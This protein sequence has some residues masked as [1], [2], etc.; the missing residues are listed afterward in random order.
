MLRAKG[1]VSAGLFG[2]KASELRDAGDRGGHLPACVWEGSPFWKVAP[3]PTL[4][5]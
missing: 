2:V 1:S 4:Y 5:K 3:G